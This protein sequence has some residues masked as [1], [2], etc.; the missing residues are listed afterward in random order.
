M[1]FFTRHSIG[2]AIRGKGTTRETHTQS[3]EDKRGPG[4]TFLSYRKGYMFTCAY[5]REVEKLEI[6]RIFYF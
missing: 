6:L 1:G 2:D 4:G 5:G 3:D